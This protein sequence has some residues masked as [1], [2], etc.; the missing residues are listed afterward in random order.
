[1]RFATDTGGTF[2]DLVIEDDTGGLALFKAPT[3][4]LDPVAG[5][6]RVLQDA[7]DSRNQSLDQLLGTG[8]VFIHGTTHALNALI[9]GNTARTALLTTAGHPDILTLREGGRVDPFDHATAYPASFIPPSLTL[10]VEER[11]SAQ[12]DV[13]T[14]LRDEQVLELVE[15]LKQVEVEAISVCLLWSVVNPQHERQIG[16]LLARHLPDVPVTLSH[17]LNPVLREYRRASSASI[18]A[19]LKPTMT[20][21]LGNLEQRLREAG[22]KGRV[23]VISSQGG[24]LDASE[25]AGAP[26]HVLNS[27]PSMAP[28]A[29]RAVTSDRNVIVADTGGTTYD[30]SVVHEGQIPLSR[31]LWIGGP[32]VG[33]M[34]GFPSVDVKSIGSGGG[35][36][37]RVDEGGVLHVGPQ[38]QGSDPG[39]ACYG[40]GGEE[41][42]L[43]DAS[44]VLGYLDPGNFLGGKMH[45]DRKL[46]NQAI[47]DCIAKPLGLSIA[48]AALSIVEVATEDMCQ[49][50]FDFSG[51]HGI[52]PEEAV[53]IGAGGAAGLNTVAVSRRLGCR[54]VI[55]PEVGATMSAVGALVTDISR[56]FRAALMVSSERFDYE[57]VNRMLLDLS[58]RCWRFIASAGSSD[59]ESRIILSVEA[60]YENQAWDIVVPLPISSFNSAQDLQQLIDAFHREHY[61]LF[62]YSDEGSSIEISNW[63]SRVE[64][65]VGSDCMGRLSDRE[66]VEIPSLRNCMFSGHGEVQASIYR[67]SA[68]KPGQHYLGPAIIESPFTSVVIDPGI[69]FLRSDSGNVE[70]Q[71]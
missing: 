17:E 70:V 11:I 10:E 38:S 71:C 19:A 29:G 32:F 31:E 53:L 28:V 26:I 2:T 4:K 68:L 42:T 15:Q 61:R 3:N 58:E 62:A 6:I 65:V 43:T 64:C 66:I 21:Y 63:V 67:W 40:K 69:E 49:A 9:T 13:L 59:R 33:H 18:D 14:A 45:L 36:I 35:S 46:A 56:E 23:L 27:G 25:V 52:D 5:V 47:G 8:E 7:A 51:S 41:A 44:L 39:P 55:I 57:A 37:A 34:T 54:K 1:M 50:I 12:G 30:L 48:E 22:F 24:L 16:K 20:H 60:H